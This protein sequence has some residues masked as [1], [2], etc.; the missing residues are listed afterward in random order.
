M[1]NKNPKTLVILHGWNTTGN[2][3]WQDF[4]QVL[5]EKDPEL[6]IIAPTMPGFGNSVPPEKIWLAKDYAN[7][8][9]SYLNTEGVKG[10]IVLAGHSFGGAVASNFTVQYPDKVER[11]ILIAPAIIR[12]QKNQKR[13]TIQKITKL[14][15]NLFKLPIVKNFYSLFRKAWYKLINSPDYHKTSGIMSEIMQKV[16][17]DDQQEVVKKIKQPTLLC[18]G[19]KDTYTPFSYANRVKD[20]IPNSKLLVFE[21]INHGVHLHAKDKLAKEIVSFI[22]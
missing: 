13:S 17:I 8:L 22:S 18:W 12:E 14:G 4:I 15:K 9:N 20:L 10:K 3:S 11:L 6:N 16:I 7:W 19:T 1:P 21:G 2:G 5:K